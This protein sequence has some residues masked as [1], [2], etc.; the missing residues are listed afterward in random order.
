MKHPRV[1]DDDEGIITVEYDGREL[2]G[3]T[4]NSEDER[5][6]KMVRAREYVEGWYDGT[7]CQDC[8]RHA[9]ELHYCRSVDQYLC[10]DCRSKLTVDPDQ[11]PAD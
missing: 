2:R 10:D 11:E 7:G 3:F 6:I 5:R 1:V 9:A 4:Y 8:R